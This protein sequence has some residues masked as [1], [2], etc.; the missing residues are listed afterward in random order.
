MISLFQ[1]M[2]LFQHSFSVKS[3]HSDKVALFSPQSDVR[4]KF[5]F[6]I[7][8]QTAIRFMINK[9]NVCVNTHFINDF[10]LQG[11]VSFKLQFY[12]N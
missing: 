8:K 9:K 4:N 11:V 3:Q 2:F 10:S 12:F 1:Q 7:K 6:F 5:L